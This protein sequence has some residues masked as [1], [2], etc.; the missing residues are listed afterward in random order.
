MEPET[1]SSTLLYKNETVSLTHTIYL[2][3][4]DLLPCHLSAA[5]F[6]VS[7]KFDEVGEGNISSPK[8]IAQ[9][10]VADICHAAAGMQHIILYHCTH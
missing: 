1:D 3:D 9:H 7:A 2:K 5:S 8:G 4:L 6:Y 10:D